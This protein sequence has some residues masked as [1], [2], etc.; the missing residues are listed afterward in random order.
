MRALDFTIVSQKGTIRRFVAPEMLGSGTL[1]LC[2]V[3]VSSF[4]P[5]ILVV[6]MTRPAKQ[7]DDRPVFPAF[8][9]DRSRLYIAPLTP[10]LALRLG[11]PVAMA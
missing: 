9:S 2:K 6:L 4:H 11:W 5:S 8:V 10:F 1:S 3:V 7:L